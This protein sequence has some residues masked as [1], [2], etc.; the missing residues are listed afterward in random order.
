MRILHVNK[1]LYRR[2]GA[3]AYMMDLAAGQRAAGDEVDFYAMQHPE[4]IPATFEDTFP[5]QAEF[6]TVDQPVTE[7]IRVV[8]RAFYSSTARSGIDRVAREFEP[9]IVHLH[10]IY[11][12]LS[13]SILRPLASLGIPVVMTLHDYKL[14]C[15][16]YRFLADGRVCEACIGG[17][18]WNAP[19]KKCN[20]GSLGASIVVAAETALHRWL[21]AYGS[22]RRF[23]CPSEFLRSK[24]IEANVFPDRM[25]A[26]PN[27]APVETIPLKASPGGDVIYIGRLSPEKGVDTLIRAAA[28]GRFAVRIVGDGPERRALESLSSDVGAA[29]T[30]EGHLGK[31]RLLELLR[32]SSV[33]VLPARW[34]ENQPISIIESFSAGVPVVATDLGGLPELI[35]PGETGALVPVDDPQ[36]LAAALRSYVDEPDMGLRQG[37]TARAFAEREFTP[38]VHLARMR[39]VYEQAIAG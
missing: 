32:S 21:K 27:F 39:R 16:S 11:H 33:S 18:F 15:P 20:K 24:M 35:Q 5:R 12:Q 17:A 7:R 1:F 14:A 13:P 36:S 10:N 4:N 23:L 38:K 29:A 28:L 37:R 8:G 19:L 3:E 22:I 6:G 31:E 25:H 30:F 26:I 34:Y 9:D 2:G